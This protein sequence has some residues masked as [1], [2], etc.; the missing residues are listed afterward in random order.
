MHYGQFQALFLFSLDQR[1]EHWKNSP[2]LLNNIKALTLGYGPNSFSYIYPTVQ[3]IPENQAPHSHNLIINLAVENGVLFTALL[4]LIIIKGFRTLDEQYKAAVLL[5]LIHNLVDLNIQFPLTV[6][7]LL[8]IFNTV[9]KTDTAKNWSTFNTNVFAIIILL[10][11]MSGNFYYGHKDKLLTNNNRASLTKY[12]QEN[13]LD[14]K[15]LLKL[16]EKTYIKE[17]FKADPYN[18]DHLVKLLEHYPAT[19]LD[20][21]WLENY[22]KWYISHSKYNLNYI[23]EKGTVEK[24]KK[25]FELKDPEFANSL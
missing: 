23:H 20:P 21:Q 19:Q 5:F 7:I 15:Q 18:V 13:P 10:L 17:V 24:L 6:F 12:I 1:I 14:S 3:Q 2:K 9:N 16:D 8:L 22:K 11:S 25:T 4:L